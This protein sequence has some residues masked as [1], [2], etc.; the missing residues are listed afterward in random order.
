[1][2]SARAQVR[3]VLGGHLV[4]SAARGGAAVVGWDSNSPGLAAAAVLLVTKAA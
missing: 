4:G 2:A 3:P 1:M